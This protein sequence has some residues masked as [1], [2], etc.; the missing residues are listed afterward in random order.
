V[1]ILAQI[2]S[3]SG[4]STFQNILA[5]LAAGLLGSVYQPQSLG[6]YGG[7]A[8]VQFLDFAAGVGDEAR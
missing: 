2:F 6:R 3:Y 5:N 8:L 7:F 1:C 4:R